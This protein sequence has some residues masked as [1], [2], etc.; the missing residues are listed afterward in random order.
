[1]SAKADWIVVA[2]FLLVGLGGS[3]RIFIMMRSADTRPVNAL[4]HSHARLQHSIP[5]QQ[6]AVSDAHLALRRSSAVDRRTVA[7]TSLAGLKALSWKHRPLLLATVL[8]SA[9]LVAWLVR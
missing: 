3:L 7:R 4:P 9:C 8:A 2:G 6:A 1:M 5:Q